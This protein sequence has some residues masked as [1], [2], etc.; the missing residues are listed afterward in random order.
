ML[1]RTVREHR[2]RINCGNVASDCCVCLP[3]SRYYE[4]MKIL[5]DANKAKV[6][7]QLMEEVLKAV[8]ELPPEDRDFE[9]MS[10]T[11]VRLVSEL[12]LPERDRM[13]L[14]LAI[15]FRMMA[16]GRLTQQGGGRGWTFPGGEG[17]TYLHEELI[18]AAAE[19]PMVMVDDEVTFDP[20]SFHRRLL[21]LAEPHG[22]A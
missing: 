18:R 9:G 6:D 17:C 5:R 4:R 12:G 3:R 22:E 19:E 15:N 14:G 16:L 21:A 2:H 20:D 13:K 1:V 11:I 8:D 7:P 10:I